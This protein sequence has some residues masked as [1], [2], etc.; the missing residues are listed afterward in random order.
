[1]TVTEGESLRLECMRPKSVPAAVYT[2]NIR[3]PDNEDHLIPITLEK[4]THMD[5]KGKRMKSLYQHGEKDL[6]E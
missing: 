6:E 5:Q 1:M 4:R 2:W 3:E